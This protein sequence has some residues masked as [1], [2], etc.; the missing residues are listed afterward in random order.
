[1]QVLRF[2]FLSP[3]N[4]NNVAEHILNL[5]NESTLLDEEETKII[6]LKVSDISQCDKYDANPDYITNN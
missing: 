2:N 3:E 6:V 4:A 1:M 5:I